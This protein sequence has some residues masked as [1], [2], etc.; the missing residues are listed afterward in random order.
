M[1]RFLLG[2]TIGVI[3]AT[4][5]QAQSTVFD[6]AM[7]TGDAY[8]KLGIYRKAEKRYL[9]ALVEARNCGN[10][11]Q[12]LQALRK[13]GEAYYLS[14]NFEDSEQ[15]FRKALELSEQ[16]SGVEALPVV[17]ELNNLV[18]SLRRQNKWNDA[19]PHIRRVITLRT[20]LL[21]DTDRL[22]SNSWLDLAVNLQ[23]Q[24][25]LGDSDA[26]FGKARTRART[27]AQKSHRY[28]RSIC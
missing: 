22:I 9:E 10:H 1:K 24:G 25:R 20:K 4:P 19:D 3:A 14:G 17:G 15:I 26:A 27:S 8:Y 7:T 21:P 5:V 23:R 11:E 16:V 28:P 18:K 12:E 2:I 13:L 6:D